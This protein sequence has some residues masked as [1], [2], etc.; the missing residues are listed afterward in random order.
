VRTCSRV[1]WILP[2]YI[3]FGS[4]S[5][6]TKR[7]TSQNTSIVMEKADIQHEDTWGASVS[8]KF[9]SNLHTLSLTPRPSRT[10]DSPVPIIQR[11]QSSPPRSSTESDGLPASPPDL[12]PHL[13]RSAPSIVK[14]RTGSVLSRGFILKTDFYPSGE[15]KTLH[16]PSST[17]THTQGEHLTL[18]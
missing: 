8:P 12:M 1:L 15:S 7:D 11:P 9:A 13:Q 3:Y 5:Y 16:A 14:T 4:S 18:T 17:D 6:P 10:S 2:A